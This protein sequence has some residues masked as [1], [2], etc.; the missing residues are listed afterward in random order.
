MDARP[1]WWRYLQYIKLRCSGSFSL[2]T[3]AFFDVLCFVALEWAEET[4]S[5]ALKGFRWIELSMV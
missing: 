4:L 3:P 1:G 5:F 2:V